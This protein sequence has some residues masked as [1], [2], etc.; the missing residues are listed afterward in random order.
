MLLYYFVDCLATP[1]RIH[2]KY[3]VR[4]ISNINKVEP[5]KN[6]KK[7]QKKKTGCH[8]IVIY[9]LSVVARVS[10]LLLYGTYITIWQPLFSGV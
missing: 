4:R 3:A 6:K 7:K 1:D 5:K 9:V 2:L 10:W 8:I